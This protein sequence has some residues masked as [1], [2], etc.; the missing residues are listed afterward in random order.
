[1]N[2]LGPR[3]SLVGTVGIAFLLFVSVIGFALADTLPPGGSFLDDDGNI[4]EGSIEA[5]AAAGITKG[6]NP[7]TNNLYCPSDKV[8]R[9][10]M[11][12]FLTRALGLT[13]R[14]DDP[15]TDDDGS[16]FEADIE[17]MAAA[18]ITKGCNPPV[19]D[20]FCPH[21]YV[22]RGQMAAFL[23]R[24]LGYTDAG[25]GD[26]FT[27]DDGLIFEPSID[28]L[29]TAGVTR[30]CNPPVNDQF[31]PHSPV[32]RDQM[33]SF[34][35]RALG[36]T[37]ITPPPP[38][39]ST[40]TTTSG[41]TTGTTL[42]PVGPSAVF[43]GCDTGVP[44][45]HFSLQQECVEGVVIQPTW[46]QASNT[47]FYFIWIGPDGQQVDQGCPATGPCSVLNFHYSSGFLMGW[48][49]LFWVDA[50]NRDPGW[51][52][53]EVWSGP[54][55][56]NPQ[57]LELRDSFYLSDIPPTPTTTT[58][59]TTTTTL[60]PL[61]NVSW[62]CTVGAGN[63]RSCSGNIDTLDPADESW[64]CTPTESGYPDDN[65]PWNCSGDIDKRTAGTETWSCSSTGLCSGNIDTSDGA[66]EGWEV[67]H[68]SGND[69]FE[70][71]GD[72]E[73]SAD[74]DESWL[75]DV[76]PNGLSCAMDLQPWSWT[77]DGVLADWHSYGSAWS[78]SGSIGRLAPIVGPVPNDY[79]WW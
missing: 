7:P 62:D 58:T 13:D 73:K 35:T 2:R 57:T 23:V 68:L 78:C 44:G 50:E 47:D 71:I 3:K 29:G 45:D 55:F 37:P 27:D 64:S 24:A 33:A 49:A 18:G 70:G 79:V 12:A 76:D 61:P 42:P 32:L 59:T 4:H 65:V 43:Q 66:A 46:A 26:L 67:S 77:C 28:R 69:Q 60:P 14:L 75:C 31:C 39:S 10:Q 16:I 25:L 8:N 56:G 63:V 34:L 1:M 52:A 5:I 22:T 15:F 72:I 21:E 19:N 9:G 30:G 20:L 11:A 38:T 40:T 54:A 74:G 48:T 36:L 51:Y 6:C 41:G 53:L 17:R